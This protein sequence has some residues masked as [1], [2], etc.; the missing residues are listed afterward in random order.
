MLSFT[1][2]CCSVPWARGLIK[3]NLSFVIHKSTS[4]YMHKS[5]EKPQGYLHKFNDKSQDYLDKFIE[6]PQHIYSISLATN[7]IF[8]SKML[9]L[10]S[11]M[12]ILNLNFNIYT[13]F[14][15][16]HT[17]LN[18]FLNQFTKPN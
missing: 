13:Q 1:F 17:N 6:K 9:L 7:P 2:N 3:V 16:A 8:N 15:N 10:Y 11:K 4:I 18:I 5:N 12:L 14:Q